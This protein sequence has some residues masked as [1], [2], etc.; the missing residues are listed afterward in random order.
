VAAPDGIDAEALAK[1][2][3]QKEIEVVA[4]LHL[5]N[6]SATVTTVDLAPGYIDENMGTS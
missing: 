3:Q 5:G 6:G 4:D 1:S 2:M